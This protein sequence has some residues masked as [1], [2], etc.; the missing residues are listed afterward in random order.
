MAARGEPNIIDRSQ[1]LTVTVT[2]S[3]PLKARDVPPEAGVADRCEVMG[4]DMFEAVPGDG[5]LYVLSR[6]IHDCEDARA[7]TVLRNCR[8][9][10]HGQAHLILVEA[11]SA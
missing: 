10:M 2:P 1:P 11:A 5:D 8:H 3:R 4:G 6:V 9:A 7:E